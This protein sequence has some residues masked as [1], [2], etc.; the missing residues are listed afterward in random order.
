MWI[1]VCRELSYREYPE[2]PE[3]HAREQRL[4]PPFTLS[5]LNLTVAPHLIWCSGGCILRAISH[6]AA[7]APTGRAEAFVQLTCSRC[8]HPPGVMHC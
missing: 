7:L 8:V 3:R 4:C 1:C 6:L 2:Q 5:D